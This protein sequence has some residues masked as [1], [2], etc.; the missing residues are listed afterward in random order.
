MP[1]DGESASRLIH[2]FASFVSR[3]M[4]RFLLASLAT[5]LLAFAPLHAQSSKEFLRSNPKFLQNFREVVAQHADSTVRVACDGKDTALGVVVDA[6]G[7]ILTKACDLTGKITC[8]LKSND[9]IE[10]KIVGVHQ[11]HDLAL[12]KIDMK[13]LKPITFT[14]SKG[15]KAGSWIASVGLGSDP[16]AVG[17]V[18]VA[19]RT[20]TTKA[21]PFELI[22]PTKAAFL[23]VSTEP[24]DMGVRVAQVQPNSAAANAGIQADDLL[25]KLDGMLIDGPEF[26]L[27]QMIQRRPGDKIKLLVKRGDIEKE[28][29]A[30]LQARPKGGNFRADFQNRMGSE[31]SSRRTGYPTFLQHD[32]ILKPSDCGGPLVD[33]DG[34]VIGLNICRAGRVESWAIPTEII[35]AVLPDLK[36]GKLAPKEEKA[37]QAPADEAVDKLLVAMRDRLELMQDVAR[38]K[39]KSGVAIV[40]AEREKLLM[41]RLV[42][43]GKKLGLSEI[44]TSTLMQ[45]QFQ[46][47]QRVQANFHKKW[48]ASKVDQLGTAEDLKKALATLRPQVERQSVAVLAAYAKA[49]VE[50]GR[51]DDL[52][53]R[54]RTIVTGNSIDD[55]IRAVLLKGLWA[56]IE[57]K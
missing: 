18:S 35:V 11:Q 3:N 31:L 52:E 26:I 49:K 23:G 53:K 57:K 14:P 21:N 10:A 38:A 16:I 19:T 8:K 51:I 1:I 42:E 32:S 5:L 13:G 9:V 27:G 33:L 15:V 36:S 45:Y 40:D 34:K 46:A 4:V 55:E 24:A 28:M 2:P 29:E 44:E 12:L 30:T 39:W 50:L 6:D 54:F 17:V 20:L 47:A 41:V 22:D 48:S 7:W 25:L 56:A 43:A 37:S